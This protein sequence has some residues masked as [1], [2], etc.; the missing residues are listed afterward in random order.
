MDRAQFDEPQRAQVMALL[1]TLPWGDVEREIGGLEVVLALAIEATGDAIQLWEEEGEECFGDEFELSADQ[2][3]ALD[4]E[5][6]LAYIARLLHTAAHAYESSHRASC[7]DAPPRATSRHR[8]PGR[9][10]LVLSPDSC[11]G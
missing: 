6:R 3:A 4:D 9:T 11:A 10:N 5:W 8:W 7:Q 2:V 1:E